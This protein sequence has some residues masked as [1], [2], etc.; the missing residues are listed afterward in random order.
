M[1]MVS[2]FAQFEK[3]K[4]KSNIKL[5][6]CRVFIMDDCEDLIPEYLYFEKEEAYIK[7][8]EDLC[9]VM[10]NILYKKV[11]RVVVSTRLVSFPCC[12]VTS[13]YE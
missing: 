6:V 11:E 13:Q 5:Y 1:M 2:S 4:S 10:K 12:I 9:K 3:E 8:F 7:K